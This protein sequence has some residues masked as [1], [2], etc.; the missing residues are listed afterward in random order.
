[1]NR[2]DV[3]AYFRERN[4]GSDYTEYEEEADSDHFYGR[5]HDDDP[6]DWWKK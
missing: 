4:F 3:V 6:A 5:H 1:M 2:S